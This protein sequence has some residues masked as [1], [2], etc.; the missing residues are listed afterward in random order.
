L[1]NGDPTGMLSHDQGGAYRRNLHHVK[2]LST[3]LRKT[4]SLYLSENKYRSN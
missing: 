1:L 4:L 2:G 3:A